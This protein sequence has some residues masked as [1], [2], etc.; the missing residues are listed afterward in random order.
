MTL[1]YNIQVINAIPPLGVITKVDASPLTQW[2]AGQWL[3][4][5]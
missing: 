2:T 1:V 4:S 5:A 3:F